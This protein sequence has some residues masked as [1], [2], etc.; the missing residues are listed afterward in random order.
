MN[1]DRLLA[2]VRAPAY[3][4]DAIDELLIQQRAT[5]PMLVEGERA[6]ASSPARRLGE[7][8][9]GIV[10]Q[11]NL[12]RRASTFAKTDAASIEARPCFLCEANLP[13]E[14]RGV[15]FG[16]LVAMA[17]PF[18]AVPDHL[19]LADRQHVPQ[20]LLGRVHSLHIVAQALGPEWFVLYN[21]SA[22]GA[23]APDH[24]HLQAG[25]RDALPVFSTMPSD[26]RS[27]VSVVTFGSRCGL[28]V[29]ADTD[30]EVTIAVE[31]ILTAL[32]HGRE[33]MVN[34]I[35]T[36]GPDG[37]HTL[38]FPRRRHRSEAFGEPDALA[39][40]PAALEMGGLVIIG[41]G[42]QFEGVTLPQIEALYAEVCVSPQDVR[43]WGL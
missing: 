33:P 14:E 32:G 13:D 30:A 29:R 19:T 22:C 37:F 11:A 7:E 27:G 23:S 38:I 16:D 35:G 6:L 36:A 15:G 41:D 21:G 42:E 18:P 31:A 3:L 4:S 1:P 39:I 24:F 43:G 5:W 2:E 12:R 34:I 17:N 10:L 20:L 8:A 26:V 9:D 40:S 28:L 25:R